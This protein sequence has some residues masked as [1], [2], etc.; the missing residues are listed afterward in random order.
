M[1]LLDILTSPW[2]IVPEKLFEIQSIY[3]THLRGDK[4]DLSGLE[5]KLGKPLNNE[6]KSYELDR[7]VAIIAIDGVIAKKMNMFTRISGGVSTQILQKD[8]SAAMADPEVKAIL[9][10]VD[11]PGGTVDGT[12]DLA[13]TIYEARQLGEKPIVAF[14]DGLMASAAYWIASSA[15]RIYISGETPWVGSIGV[16]TSHIDY[17]KYE[18][19]ARPQDDRDLRGQIQAHRFRIRSPLP[20]RTRIFA[21]AGRLYLFAL[22][23]DCRASAPQS[24]NSSRRRPHPLGRRKN[25]HRQTGDRSGTCGRCFHEGSHHRKALYR[26][27][28]NDTQGECL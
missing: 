28:T 22:R 19:K 16:V 4:I 5:S 13:R 21:I 7:G 25:I 11:S 3:A 27:Q 12:E 2:A 17:S 8:F 6:Q 1:K 14:T 23:G 18:E 26:G 10:D 20:G 9:L 15:D 24:D